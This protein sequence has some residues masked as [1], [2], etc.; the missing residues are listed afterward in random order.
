MGFSYF[1]MEFST[2]FPC[3]EMVP[4]TLFPRCFF[5]AITPEFRVIKRFPRPWNW[6]PYSSNGT[7]PVQMMEDNFKVAEI[8]GNRNFDIEKDGGIIFC[9]FLFFVYF[10]FCL[11]LFFVYFIFGLFLL[12]V[13][14]YFFF[15]FSLFLFLVYFYFWFIFIKGLFFW[16]I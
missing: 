1:E 5:C 11:F 9:L 4:S 2:R 8:R 6:F 14:F 12:K 3:S 7:K 10:I 15:I 13:Y 16:F